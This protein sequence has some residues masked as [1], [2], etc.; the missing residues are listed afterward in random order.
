MENQEDTV[1]QQ[2]LAE[3]GKAKKK[4]WPPLAPQDLAR[5]LDRFTHFSPKT[6]NSTVGGIVIRL[7]KGKVRRD[8]PYIALSV[9]GAQHADLDFNEGGAVYSAKAPRQIKDLVTGQSSGVEWENIPAADQALLAPGNT[10]EQA[11][12]RAHEVLPSKVP[13]L[14][15][16]VIVPDANGQDLVLTPIGALGLTK[17]I[18]SRLEELSKQEGDNGKARGRFW[19]TAINNLGGSKAQNLGLIGLCAGGPRAASF[20]WFFPA[21]SFPS[22]HLRQRW[23]GMFRSFRHPLSSAEAKKLRQALERYEQSPG[24]DTERPLRALVRKF[25]KAAQKRSLDLQQSLKDQLWNDIRNDRKAGRN[26]H[27]EI[28][29]SQQAWEALWELGR[30]PEIN[31]AAWEHVLSKDEQ[32]LAWILPDLRSHQWAQ[33]AGNSLAGQWLGQIRMPISGHARSLMNKTIATEVMP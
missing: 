14:L 23:A 33:W 25:G 32:E 7:E 10:Y 18:I 2:S 13:T 5:T 19:R 8:L 9:L 21:P 16:Q 31:T 22:L 20:A 12:S 1:E 30:V 4:S 15:R 24:Q 29:S 17:T 28:S 11:L 6:I 27:E 3:D 26:S